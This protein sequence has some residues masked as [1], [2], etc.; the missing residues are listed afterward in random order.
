MNAVPQLTLAWPLLSHFCGKPLG[1]IRSGKQPGAESGWGSQHK[2]HG[3]WVSVDGADDWKDWCESEGFRTEALK[4]RYRVTLKDPARLLWITEPHELIEFTER[5]DKPVVL[6]SLGARVGRYIDWP[7]VA[8]DYPGMVIAPYQWSL[9]LA[10]GTNWYY[11][12]DCASGCIWDARVIA[13]TELLRGD[14]GQ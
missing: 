13:S 1:K 9:R 14:T 3:F 11:S 4:L 8:A 6:G 7:R 2:P 5:Y 10:E 12:W